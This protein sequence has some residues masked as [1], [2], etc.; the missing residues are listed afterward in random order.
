MIK[1]PPERKSTRRKVKQKS[2]I[3][4]IRFSRLL[5]VLILLS[6]IIYGLYI[7][8]LGI[9]DW[10][11]YKYAQYRETRISEQT[12]PTIA[13]QFTDK[14]FENYTNVLVIGIDD[15]PVEGIGEAGRYADAVMLISMNNQT[16]E[17]RFLSL[18]RNMKI[19]IPGRKDPDYL[20]FTYYYG[21]SLLTVDTVSQLLNIPITQYVALDRK[22]LSRLVDTIGGIN[23][24]VEHNMNYDDPA[25][26]TSI[27]LAQGYQKLTGDM[28]QQYLRYRNDDLGDIGRVQRQQK[29]AKALFEKL[30]SWETVPAIP[31]LV[32][33]LEDNMDTNINILDINNVIE[34]L[35]GLR[36]NNVS[37]KMLPGNLSTTGD[38]IPDT[39]RIEEDMNEMFPPVADSATNS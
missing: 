23:I 12:K 9:Y 6:G 27:H 32:R 35:G 28:S 16:G 38:W 39:N 3:K 29:F 11:S 30:F 13:P 15:T 2:L 25:S 26:K 18:P 21:G 31:S 4:R 33:I 36:G 1:K 24:Y 34:I 22:A 7:A 19:D 37:I 14:R 17:V 20:S 8:L 10:G 5:L